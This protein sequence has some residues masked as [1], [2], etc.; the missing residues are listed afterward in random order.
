MADIAP[1]CPLCVDLD[2]TLT[3]SDTL[4]EGL[5]AL[6]ASRHLPWA[7]HGL[8]TGGRALLKQRVAEATLMDATLLPY[9]TSLLTYLQEEKR[10][11]RQLVL[12]TAADISVARGV[13]EHHAGL[14]DEVMASD[15]RRNLKGEA[16][17]QA[18]VERFGAG[19]FAY[20]GNDATDVAIW[21]V[22]Q[23]GILVNASRRTAAAARR[24]T[25]VEAE[26]KRDMPVPLALL[27]AMRPH[28]WAKNLLVIVPVFTAHAALDPA[29]W[30]AALLAFV[31]FCAT[32]SGIYLF[33][34]LT[35]LAADRRHP[36]KRMRPFASGAVPL[37]TGFLTGAALLAIGLLLA[38][39][40]G[41]LL[42]LLLYAV[43]SVAY[44]MKLK[45]LPLVDVFVLAALYTLRIVAGG[46]A[47]GH[48]ISLWLICF[49]SFLFLSLAL[50]K[51]VEELQSAAE[52]GK[53]ALSRRGYTPADLPI[54][55]G[56]GCASAFSASL[57][58]AL[59]VQ[60]EA[61]QAQRYASP[62][63]LW[64]LVPLMLFWQCRL[65]LSAA[66]GYMHDDPIIYA[67]RDWVSWLVALCV[68]LVLT[69][70]KSVT[71]FAP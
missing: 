1:S 33:N 19:N 29:S 64:A 34:D 14:F 13:A 30:M 9:N 20:I 49:S 71:W 50:V 10:R 2:G 12:V 4:V 40:A 59:F 68:F 61:M 43:L 36:R 37:T 11:G 48:I 24:A 58:L 35:D 6:L 63:L 51:R 26:F 31:A 57:V 32:A 70:A 8:L 41:A 45:E 23:A 28:Q 62:A 47:T 7:L 5:L 39:A 55:R 3:P 42:V 15:G 16:K 18:L 67:A 65:W 21:R 25:R 60:A 22:A 52:R 44:S 56:F 17:A 38:A 53:G 69:A 27:R 46:E 54:L 66:R